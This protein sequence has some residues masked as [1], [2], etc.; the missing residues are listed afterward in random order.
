MITDDEVMRV[1]ERADP[2]RVDDAIPLPDVADYFDALRT[3]STTATVIDIE[4]TPTR[5]HRRRVVVA[6]G[7]AAAVVAITAGLVPAVSR[8]NS[9]PVRPAIPPTTRPSPITAAP[10]TTVAAAF[11]ARVGLIGLPPEGADA[12]SARTRR[13]GR[14]LLHRD[15]WLSVRRRRSPLRRRAADLAP[16]TSPTRSGP[17]RQGGWSSA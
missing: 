8:D 6:I 17:P 2:A 7:V 10:S 5:R 14:Q 16:A 3:R 11:A 9:E 4:P 1:L 12:Q 15:R 13:T